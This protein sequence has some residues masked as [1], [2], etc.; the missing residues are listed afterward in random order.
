MSSLCEVPAGPAAPI[1][2]TNNTWQ[3]IGS[4]AICAK[5]NCTLGV[6]AKALTK[7]GDNWSCIGIC[8]MGSPKAA[9]SGKDLSK[10]LSHDPGHN[11][12]HRPGRGHGLTRRGHHIC[13]SG[14]KGSVLAPYMLIV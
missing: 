3:Q 2:G 11:H 9:S 6:L 5:Q 1:P 8:Y 4:L 14:S 12:R 10:G 7:S 13:H